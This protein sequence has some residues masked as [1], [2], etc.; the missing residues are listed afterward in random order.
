[1]RPPSASNH[2]GQIS[3]RGSP[4]TWAM[5]RLTRGCGMSS[6][7]DAADRVRSRLAA[8]ATS[9]DPFLR[10]AATISALCQPSRC[11]RRANCSP[12]AREWSLMADS[13][14]SWTREWSYMT[15]DVKPALVRN[16]HLSRGDAT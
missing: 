1:M 15:T 5:A 6:A 14:Q 4:M 10:T 12:K 16:D 8:I 7:R 3:C 2:C 9:D 11:C 13:K